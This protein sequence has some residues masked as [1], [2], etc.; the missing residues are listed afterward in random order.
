MQTTN[1]CTYVPHS[2]VQRAPLV[3]PSQPE[4]IAS[5]NARYALTPNSTTAA[6]HKGAA[7]RPAAMVR[8]QSNG[9]AYGSNEVPA[10]FETTTRSHYVSFGVRAYQAAV[11]PLDNVH[12]L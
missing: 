10:V 4:L 11:K 8:P 12:S 3:P 5:E 1:R 9:R 6:V 7:G 2:N